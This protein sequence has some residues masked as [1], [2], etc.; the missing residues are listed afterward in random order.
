MLAKIAAFE[1]RYQLKNPVLWVSAGMFFLLSFGLTASES[2][3]IG[4]GGS[5][6]HEN[7]PFAIAQSQLILSIFYMFVATAP[8][9]CAVRPGVRG[10]DALFG[11]DRLRRQHQ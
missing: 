11:I 6:V 4:P 8:G 5:A 3:R 1:F 7:G 9:L 10:Y 2:V